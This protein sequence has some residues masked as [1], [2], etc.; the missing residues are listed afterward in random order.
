MDCL[1]A[2]YEWKSKIEVEQLMSDAGFEDFKQLVRG[3]SSDPIEMV[4][5][6][7]PYADVKYGDAQLKYL[8]SKA[9][10]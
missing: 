4:S 6:N 1:Y 5:Q 3:V 7:L 8:A 10:Y 2:P 9:Q